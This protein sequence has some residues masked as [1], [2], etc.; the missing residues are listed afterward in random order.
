M[1]DILDALLEQLSLPQTPQPATPLH[2]DLHEQA[3]LSLQVL[4]PLQ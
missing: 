4:L 3:L 1:M 2:S